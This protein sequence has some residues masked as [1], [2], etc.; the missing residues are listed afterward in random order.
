MPGFTGTGCDKMNTPARLGKHDEKGFEARL[1]SYAHIIVPI[2]LI[3]LMI[4]ISMLFVAVL[5]H[6][7]ATESGVVYNHLK[8]VI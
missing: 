4:L 3:I 2:L 1:N 5:G 6:V 8:D 7:S